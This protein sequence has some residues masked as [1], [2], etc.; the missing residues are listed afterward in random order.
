MEV[1]PTKGCDHERAAAPC[2]GTGYLGLPFEPGSPEGRTRAQAP[3][4]SV[5]ISSSLMHEY[6]RTS[7]NIKNILLEYERQHPYHGGGSEEDS[8]LLPAQI[9]HR[10][11]TMYC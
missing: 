3:G 5:N 4:V 10:H 11:P 2:R 8:R 9:R 7:S 6:Q 1:S